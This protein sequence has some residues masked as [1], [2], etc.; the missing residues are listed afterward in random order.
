METLKEK[1]M[2]EV[3][4]TQR[5]SVHSWNDNTCFFE[6]DSNLNSIPGVSVCIS[7]R[8]CVMFTSE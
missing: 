6:Q 8:I 5:I 7:K 4:G 1:Q 2:G 3:K